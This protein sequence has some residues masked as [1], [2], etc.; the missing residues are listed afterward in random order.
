MRPVSLLQKES[1][2]SINQCRRRNFCPGKIK[3]ESRHPREEKLL[4]Y[5]I[6]K[7]EAVSTS[8]DYY[9]FF[10]EE[11]VRYHHILNP[12]TGYPGRDFWSV[13]VVS[14]KATLADI[15]S[16]VIMAGGREAL[17][18]VEKNFPEI[19]ILAVEE[20][21]NVYLSPSMEKVFFTE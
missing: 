18:V 20:G 8:G 4:G 2:S 13:T 6:I 14:K 9:Q 17:V 10:E 16:T 3:Q 11:D 21:G 5:I 19:K 15:L 7:D 12:F 1:F